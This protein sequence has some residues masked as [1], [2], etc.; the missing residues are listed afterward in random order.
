MPTNRKV[1]K[2]DSF[3][4]LSPEMAMT[5]EEDRTLHLL[6]LIALLGRRWKLVAVCAASGALMAMLIGTSMPAR[7]TAKAQLLVARSEAGPAATFDEAVVDTHVELILSP[8]HLREVQKSLAE[9]PGSSGPA[10]FHAPPSPFSVLAQQTRG[11]MREVSGAI[12]PL[13]ANDEPPPSPTTGPSEEAVPEESESIDFE[14]LRQNLNVY[15]EQRSRVVAVTFTTENPQMAAVIANRVAEIYVSR[16]RDRL[17]ARRERLEK[18]LAERIPSAR[19]AVERSEAAVRDHRMASGLIDQK[20]VETMDRQIAELRRQLA[21][22]LARLGERGVRLS[23]L[24]SQQD[25]EGPRV[26][27][28]S[29]GQPANDLLL[30]TEAETDAVDATHRLDPLQRED[31]SRLVDEVLAKLPFDRRAHGE[32]LHRTRQ[33]LDSLEQSRERLREAEAKLRELER[34][35]AA[36]AQLYESLLRRQTEIFVQDRI[37]EEAHIVS[38]ALPPEF[39]SS[40]SPV[41]FV[42]PAFVAFAIGGGLT[43]VLL[44]RFDRRVRSERDVE[45]SVGVP[46]I[47]LVPRMHGFRVIS[48]RRALIDNPFNSYGEAVRSVVATALSRRRIFP[49]QRRLR[50]SA[51]FAITSSDKDDGK[52]ALALSFAL[53]ASTIGRQVLLIDL[54]FRNPSIAHSLEGLGTDRVTDSGKETVPAEEMVKT[55]AEFGIDFLP[56][57]YRRE[58][59]LSF[60]ST[61]Q[62]ATMLDNFK[63][64]YDCIVIES[65]PLLGATEARVIA[66]V[67]DNVIFALEWSATEV[68]VARRALSQLGHVGIKDAHQR[69]FGVLTQVNV[70]KHHFR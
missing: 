12:F 47:G 23:A 32:R 68:D 15:K 31:L 41:L 6:D 20:S 34:E 57:S 46:C 66:S 37:Q 62:L 64:Q 42:L 19:A 33:R 53:S 8:S 14:V 70:R 29:D 3:A 17:Q 1:N 7:Y 26:H 51:V 56:L 69:V 44:E 24:L 39:P 52:T 22:D 28:L 2:S 25:H 59:A 9:D 36:S 65:P 16:G 54:D 67:V 21:I 49:H 30:A 55:I 43:A 60:L 61:N 40:T 63:E 27:V 58:Y 50:D 35:A 5:Y 18:E 10:T 48:A 45:E 11:K 13:G 4:P 38:A